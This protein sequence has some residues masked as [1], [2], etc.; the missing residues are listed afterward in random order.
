MKQVIYLFLILSQ[1]VILTNCKKGD[2]GPKGDTGNTALVRYKTEPAGVNCTVGGVKIETGV[3]GNGNG[4]LDDAEVTASQT[5][6]ICNGVTGPAGPNG[7]ATLTKTT[8]E[9]AGGN[10]STG[11]VKIEVGVDANSNG[12]LDASEV[13]TAM[14]RFICNGSTGL[15]SLVRT[16]AEPAGANCTYGGIKFETGTDT[17][18]N[19]VL[20]N[21]E[22]TVS[23]T[24]YVCNGAGT[25]YSNWIDVNLINNDYTNME[26]G[27]FHFKQVLNAPALTADI[28]NKG[29]V[30]MYYKSKSGVIV[31]VDKD[32]VYPINDFDIN[33]AAF[34]IQAGFAFKENY[35]SF[36]G[37]NIANVSSINDN[38]SAVRYV[39]VPGLTQGRIVTDFKKMT[40]KEVAALFNI[41]D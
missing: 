35:L 37:N 15:N 14:T 39:L 25:I 26:E 22:V 6:Y 34:S 27:A 11:G 36:L 30:L 31:P 28:A 19:G 41:K 40:Y 7:L 3:D 5:K 16:T 24:K 4:V 8:L 21:N 29:I 10:C 23:Q 18:K 13:L 9:A 17:N 1:A 20:D 2:Q 33:G 12:T 32:D 38:G